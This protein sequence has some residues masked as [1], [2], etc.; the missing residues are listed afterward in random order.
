V[1][2]EEFAE[3]L[4]GELRRARGPAQV[5]PHRRGRQHGPYRV[6]DL[7]ARLGVAQVVQAL[8]DLV[9]GFTGR[10][11]RTPVSVRVA[12]NTRDAVDRVRA[13]A[14]EPGVVATAGPLPQ[15]EVRVLPLVPAGAGFAV[16]TDAWRDL[17][18]PAGALVLDLV[19]ADHLD[20]ALIS[21]RGPLTAG[22]EAFVAHA[23]G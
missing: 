7:R 17:A 1:P 23:L 16:V 2:P 15:T 22:A 4:G 19:P 14:C 5:R 20:V 6:H 3:H 9:P 13:G 11:P 10:H 18:E 21:R 8:T 12:L